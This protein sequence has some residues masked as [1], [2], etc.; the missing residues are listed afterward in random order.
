MTDGPVEAAFTVMSDF[1]NYK[2]GI[3]KSTSSKELGAY[4][5]LLL[6]VFFVCC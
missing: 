1:E 3:Y 4:V 2:S 6:V 5:K